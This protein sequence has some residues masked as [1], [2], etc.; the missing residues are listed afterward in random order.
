VNA[1]VNLSGVDLN[2]LHV[3]D[4]LMTERSVTRAGQRVGLTQPAVSNALGRLRQVFGDE[5]FIKTANGMVPTARAE[6]LAMPIRAA[7]ETIRT[8]LSTNG[9][10]TPET[11][12]RTFTLG[13]N[14]YVEFTLLPSLM[15]ELRRVAPGIRLHVRAINR[16]TGLELLD[17]AAIDLAI[18][19]FPSIKSWHKRRLLFSENWVCVGCD[20]NPMLPEQD[21]ISLDTYLA[22]LHLVVTSREESGNADGLLGD[23]DDLLRQHGLPRRRVAATIPHFLAAPFVIERTPLL[24]TIEERL[25]RRHAGHLGLRLFKLPFEIAGFEVVQVWHRREEADPAHLWLRTQIETLAA[26]IAAGNFPFRKED[27]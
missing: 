17:T 15:Y 13:M 7:L 24:A 20:C 25:A 6:A 21:Q 5:L 12:D 4:A 11:S 8:A 23:F 18:G 16:V 3:F 9:G 27:R 19:T 2:L 22:S 14:D 26:D 1:T 10:F